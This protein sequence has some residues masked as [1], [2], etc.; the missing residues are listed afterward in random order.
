MRTS[1][2]IARATFVL[3]C[4]P[5]VM[6]GGL[7]MSFMRDDCMDNSIFTQLSSDGMTIFAENPETNESVD[8]LK[9]N[10]LT[11]RGD[12]LVSINYRPDWAAY[13]LKTRAG[14][15][16]LADGGIHQ[17]IW[18]QKYQT[19]YFVT[20]HRGLSDRQS[21]SALCSWSPQKGNRRLLSLDSPYVELR[22]SL[23]QDHL[24]IVENQALSAKA[25]LLHLPDSSV[26]DIT[27]PIE[28]S[29]AIYVKKDQFLLWSHEKGHEGQIMIWQA[30]S[31]QSPQPMT[32]DRPIIDAVA[33]DGELWALR[34]HDQ[35]PDVVLVD[36]EHLKVLKRYD[37]SVP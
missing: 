10:G 35:N 31:R 36:F 29:K 18:S 30:D 17:S 33:L 4:I 3:L 27:L 13:S 32:I 20:T 12:S 21:V 5:V 23:D 24:T 37:W 15:Y 28:T 6:C 19:L 1:D 11:R 7:F 26:R 34:H 16:Y 22:Q 8:F 25:S 14:S 9:T 2:F